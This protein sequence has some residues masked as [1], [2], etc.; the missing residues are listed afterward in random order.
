ME[1]ADSIARALRT[2]PPLRPAVALDASGGVDPD[3]LRRPLR[4]LEDALRGHGGPVAVAV[5]S[6]EVNAVANLPARGLADAAMGLVRRTGSRGG[7]NFASV[8]DW[9]EGFGHD[10]LFVVTDGFGPYPIGAGGLRVAWLLV[11]P[12]QMADVPFGE[13]HSYRTE[14]AA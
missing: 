7:T 1:N 10:A 11:G 9:A 8:V 13:A 6:S 3:D 5:F 4:D 14:A 12:D 2:P